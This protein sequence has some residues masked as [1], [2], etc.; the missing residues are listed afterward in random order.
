MIQKILILLIHSSLNQNLSQI[1]MSK[2]QNQN[3]TLN[4]VAYSGNEA[5]NATSFKKTTKHYYNLG[6]YK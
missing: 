1:Q 6:N 4:I 5:Y 3:P 2:N